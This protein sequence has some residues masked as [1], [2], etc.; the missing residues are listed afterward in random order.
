VRL[1]SVRR[2]QDERRKKKQVQRRRRVV[3]RLVLPCLS[4]HGQTRWESWLNR[5]LFF[6]F[7]HRSSQRGAAGSCDLET[8]QSAAFH[9]CAP[10]R[11]QSPASSERHVVHAT[12]SVRPSSVDSP[13]PAA[14]VPN[15]SLS[16]AHSSYRPFV[17]P[18]REGASCKRSGLFRAPLRADTR[19]PCSASLSF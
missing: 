16:A 10:P 5:L 13:S 3:R 15:A 6:D 7:N 19:P 8:G 11:R 14:P 17:A 18:N 1:C 2:F 12:V 4:S 9:S